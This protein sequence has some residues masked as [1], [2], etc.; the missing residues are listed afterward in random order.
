MADTDKL[1]AHFGQPGKK[2]AAVVLSGLVLNE[3]GLERGMACGVEMFCMGVSA[4]ET[5]SRKNTGMSTDEA[6]GQ[7]IAMAQAAMTAGKK[8]QVSVQSAFGCGFEGPDPRGAGAGHRRQS[9][10]TPASATSAWPTPP[11]T[12]IPPQVEALFAEIL[13]LRRRGRTGL[14]FPQHLRP[15]AGQLLRGHEDR[16]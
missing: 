16:A 6:I 7:I 11:A 15:G 4:S 12:P 5:H 14:P 13:K 1:F 2:P 10:W 9:T 8:V 3:K